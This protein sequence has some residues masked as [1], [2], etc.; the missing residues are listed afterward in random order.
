MQ[1]V[2][3]RSKK[4]RKVSHRS[5]VNT[6]LAYEEEMERKEMHLPYWERKAFRS[7][8]QIKVLQPKINTEMDEY[9]KIKIEEQERRL[10]T[11][12]LSLKKNLKAIDK[13]PHNGIM[14]D[15]IKFNHRKSMKCNTS[16]SAVPIRGGTAASAEHP[17]AWATQS[18]SA[19]ELAD[20]DV[21]PRGAITGAANTTDYGADKVQKFSTFRK[22]QYNTSSAVNPKLMATGFEPRYQASSAQGHRA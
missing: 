15:M 18:T 12:A 7:Y 5:D 10:V 8:K 2:A 9:I 6:S 14:S 1:S 21:S 17:V 16:A 22:E 4:S 19:Q 11:G 20:G 3:G 13:L